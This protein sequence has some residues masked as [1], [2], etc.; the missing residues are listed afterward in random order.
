M[1]IVTP[2]TVNPRAKR[3]AQAVLPALTRNTSTAEPDPRL[4]SGMM[5]DLTPSLRCVC[6]QSFCAMACPSASTGRTRETAWSATG[7]GG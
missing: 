2:M 1:K 7:R 5:V 4:Y 3:Q 6:T